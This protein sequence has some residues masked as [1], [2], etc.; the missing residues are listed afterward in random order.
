MRLSE[1]F[2]GVESVEDAA[3]R[4][5]ARKHKNYKGRGPKISQAKLKGRDPHTLYLE[6]KKYAEQGW[7]AKKIG[8][9]LEISNTSCYNYAKRHTDGDLLL[10]L[11]QNG[12]LVSA[13]K[14]T[15]LQPAVV[16]Q[17]WELTKKGFGIDTICKILQVPSIRDALIRTYGYEQYS[18]YHPKERFT[19]GFNQKYYYITGNSEKYQSWGELVIGELFKANNICFEQ[20]KLVE[21]NG[22]AFYADFYLPEYSKYVEY[23]GMENM[24][25]YRKNLLRKKCFYTK[26]NIDCLYLSP[27]TLDCKE[28]LIKQISTFLNDSFQ[29]VP[30]NLNFEIVDYVKKN[31]ISVARIRELVLEGLTVSEIASVIGVSKGLLSK[32][33]KA[34]ELESSYLQH[35]QANSKSKVVKANS[36]EFQISEIFTSMQFENN[37]VT[38]CKPSVFVRFCKCNLHCPECDSAYTFNVSQGTVYTRKEIF[39]R[40]QDHLLECPTDSITITGGESLLHQEQIESLIKHFSYCKFDIETN[41]TLIPSNFLIEH[42]NFWNVSP[43][44]SN[45]AP[46]GISSKVLTLFNNV[47]NCIYKFV[48]GESEH[49]EELEEVIRRCSIPR[50]KVVLMPMGRTP[51]ELQSKNLRVIEYCRSK[52]YRFS[53]RLHIMLYGPRRGI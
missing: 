50:D 53:P 24:P 42:V 36:L 31:S 28:L 26:N 13:R 4:L 38:F 44:L 19:T 6:I 43:K 8:A 40:I 29:Y 25:F 47:P 2:E 20:R 46:A 51:E 3:K 17:A 18:L 52:G 48:V 27:N 33:I 9:A 16:E 21:V 34:S 41:G 7:D 11:K 15:K 37:I 10:R 35:L 5:H 45:M 49:F 39:S 30:L 1:I 14:C 32:V 12:R 23:T 22:R